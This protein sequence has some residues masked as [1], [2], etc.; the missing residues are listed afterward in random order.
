[1]AKIIK[2]GSLVIAFLSNGDSIKKSNLSD[3]ELLDLIN[4]Q[5]DEEIMSVLDKDYSKKLSDYNESKNTVEQLKTSSV[6]TFDGESAYWREVSPLTLPKEL[7]KSILDAEKNNDEVRMETYK[8]FWTLMSL[9]PDETCRKNLFWYL[10]KNEL[11]I[12]RSGFFISY[13]NVDKTDEE[14]VFT[15]HHSHSM[16]IRVGEMVTMPRSKCDSDSNVTCSRGL[17]Q[18]NRFWLTKNYYGSVGLVCLTNPADVG[19][20][21]SPRNIILS[22]NNLENI[23]YDLSPRFVCSITYG[24]KLFFSN[25]IFLLKYFIFNYINNIAKKLVV[26]KLFYYS[27][28]TPNFNMSISLFYFCIFYYKFY[29]FLCF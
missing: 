19:L 10:T 9:N 26:N 11:I 7:V 28:F 3:K 2:T 24:T 21:S 16:K 29:C 14:G 17:H 8:N 18:A 5:T 27:F 1:M 22:F 6:L 25:I 20:T 13:R 23:S 15:D 12:S 4:A